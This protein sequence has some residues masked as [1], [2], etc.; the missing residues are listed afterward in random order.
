LEKLKEKKT[1]TALRAFAFI[2]LGILLLPIVNAQGPPGNEDKPCLFYGY[3]T[4]DDYSFLIKN[5]SKLFGTDLS[6][7]HN[8]EFLQIDIEGQFYARSN[9]S[10]FIT[11]EP[12]VHN[13]TIITNENSRDFKIE[14]FP[15]RLEWENDYRLLVQ[16]PETEFI[17]IDISNTR[18]I[19]ASIFSILIVFV[20]S[21]YVYWRLIES[22][23]NKNFIEE[24]VK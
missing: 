3:S 22:Y 21:T 23:V 7:F 20:L 15:D 14:I 10:M 12:G 19:W 18:E 2:T 9:N 5:N 11:I 8:C 6:F 17:S 4:S 16:D 1:H 13:L 24:V